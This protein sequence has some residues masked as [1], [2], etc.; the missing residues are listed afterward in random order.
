MVNNNGIP[1]EV[2]KKPFAEERRFEEVV[3]L[4]KLSEITDKDGKVNL[5]P[6]F[7]KKLLDPNVKK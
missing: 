3:E 7:V 6:E 5:S 1:I 4:P 2:N